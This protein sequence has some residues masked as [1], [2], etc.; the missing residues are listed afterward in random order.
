MLAR[1]RTPLDRE[2][3][4]GGMAMGLAAP[5]W[6]VE[7]G[8]KSH[9]PWVPTGV[10]PGHRA[11]GFPFLPC[12]PGSAWRFSPTRKPYSEMWDERFFFNVFFKSIVNLQCCVKF[13]M[14]SK[15]I[16]FYL[17]MDILIEAVTSVSPVQESSLDFLERNPYCSQNHC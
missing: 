17:L 12:S 15:V 16:Q 2:G 13:Q 14:S 1:D 9:V 8:V 5:G 4:W 3:T 6:G 10:H 7:R 11:D